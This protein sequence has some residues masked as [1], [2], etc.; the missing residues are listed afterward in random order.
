[1]S[2]LEES[3]AALVRYGRPVLALSS[4]GCWSCTVSLNTDCAGVCFE[5]AAS[6]S[7]HKMPAAAV[8]ECLMRTIKALANV[9][10]N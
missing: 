8:E 1:M 10:R 2:T 6:Y 7:T 9:P 4:S 3:L 5:V